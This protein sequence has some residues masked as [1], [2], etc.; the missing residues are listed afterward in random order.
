MENGLNRDQRNQIIR[1]L[2]KNDFKKI[3]YSSQNDLVGYI[4]AI[5]VS[6]LLKVI[7]HFYL[8]DNIIKPDTKNLNTLF[9]DFCTIEYLPESQKVQWQ[10]G[11]ATS[12]SYKWD[13]FML[14]G[15]EF[16][17]KAGREFLKAFCNE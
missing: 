13:Y 11:N 9:N 3:V 14:N 12:L 6:E 17:K 5:T 15:S 4:K 16:E 7:G 1:E 2:K 8:G 10:V